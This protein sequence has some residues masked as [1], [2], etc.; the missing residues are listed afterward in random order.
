MDHI[1]QKIHDLTML[2]LS[3]ADLPKNMTPA[4]L[5]NKYAEIE[6]QI[7]PEVIAKY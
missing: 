7:G 1:A 3:K 4:E 5:V 6:K 2:Y